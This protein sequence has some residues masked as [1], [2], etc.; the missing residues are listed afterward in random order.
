M[1][2]GRESS[3]FCIKPCRD[4]QE[5]VMWLDDGLFILRRPLDRSRITW[6]FNPDVGASPATWSLFVAFESL[7]MDE[8]R[9]SI[10]DEANSQLTR[11]LH[12]EHPATTIVSVKC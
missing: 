10:N 1:N 3:S 11:R 9:R 6:A 5:Q 7:L 2:E 8:S 4:A 12:T